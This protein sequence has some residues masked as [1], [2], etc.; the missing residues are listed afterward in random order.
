MFPLKLAYSLLAN[1]NRDCST[2]AQVGQRLLLTFITLC[3]DPHMADTR[4]ADRPN[5]M[6]FL[7]QT[8][9]SRAVSV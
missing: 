5:Y 9:L 1:C 4:G 8:S 2:A 3:P 7:R 6:F